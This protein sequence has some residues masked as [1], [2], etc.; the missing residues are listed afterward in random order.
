MTMLLGT[1][2]YERISRLIERYWRKN[3]KKAK[4]KPVIDPKFKSTIIL[5]DDGT[6]ML[7]NFIIMPYPKEDK[8]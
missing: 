7:F 6:P 3:I 4:K 8:K 5:A 1:G 2:S